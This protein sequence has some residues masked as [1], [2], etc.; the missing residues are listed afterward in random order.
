M[1]NYWGKRTGNINGTYQGSKPHLGSPWN[2]EKKKEKK[3]DHP[4]NW[5][6][7]SVGRYHCWNNF[8]WCQIR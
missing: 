1:I 4:L 3:D 2:G 5:A 8:M 7:S 6:P